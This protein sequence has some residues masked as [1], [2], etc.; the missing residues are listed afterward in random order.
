MSAADE[1]GDLAPH[2]AALPLATVVLAEG[3]VVAADERAR[4][5]APDGG[6]ESPFLKWFDPAD[7][8]AVER[9]LQGGGGPDEAARLAVSGRWV[10]IHAGPP[11][12]PR[13]VQLRD[14]FDELHYRAAVDV[15]ADSTFVI[16]AGGS[17]RWR[18]AKL[19]SRSGVTDAEA[20]RTPAGERIHPEDLPL[21]FEA[22][23]S[24]A[25]DRPNVVVARS[26]AVDDDDRW[27][28][29]EITVWNRIEHEVL[30]GY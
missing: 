15:V 26:R 14:A 9:A 18:S 8:G 24:T 5:W 22:F 23:A 2:G 1:P 10:A 28:T 21:V 11:E 30:N 3:H 6:W 16:E 25:V 19:R 12:E 4:Q 7:A 20:A 17:N 13:I 29:I 27:E